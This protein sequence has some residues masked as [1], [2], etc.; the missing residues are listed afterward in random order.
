[1]IILSIFMS[2]SVSDE[3]AIKPVIVEEES[4]GSESEDTGEVLVPH[5]MEQQE[6]LPFT[7]GGVLTTASSVTSTRE[8]CTGVLHPFFGAIDSTMAISIVDWPMDSLKIR[9]E[10]VAGEAI[11]DW[12]EFSTIAEYQFILPR[13]GEFFIHIEPTDIQEQTHEYEI[14]LQ[15]ISN[16]EGEFTRYPI[17]FFHGLAG[18]D[19]LLNVMDYF[20]GVDE[21]L[22]EQGYQ[23]EFPSVSAFDT[24]DNRAL[25]WQEQMN[26]L[27]EAGV[28]RRFNIIAHSQGGLDARYLASVLGEHEKIASI[29]TVSTP[30][31]GTVVSDVYTGLIEVSFWDGAIIDEIV[32]IGSLLFG[33]E[34]ENFSEQLEQMTTTNL[35]EFNEN[36]PD[37]D[38]VAYYSWAGKSCRYF[39][40]ECQAELDGEVVTSYFATTHWYVEEYQG[41]NDGLI[42]V[43]S[44]IWGE[45]LGVL[46]ADHIDQMG[47]KFDYSSQV[48][49][50]QAFYL[51]EARRLSEAGF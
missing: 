3:P 19:S 45:Y 24:I 21:M 23:A 46:P 15:C 40:F 5:C 34:G 27:V 47:H 30:H 38:G 42:A 39:Q 12:Q 44:A 51:S 43:E 48:F 18:F 49:D 20:D 8:F 32:S 35:V 6:N 4:E 1:M 25:G 31:H 50:S 22:A 2:C 7:E 26:D 36:V 10:D 14:Q 33:V 37:I 28:A 16:C 17:L 9:L 29:T 41:Y 13:S 11:L